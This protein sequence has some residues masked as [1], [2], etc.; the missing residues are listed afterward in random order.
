VWPDLVTQPYETRNVEYK[1]SGPWTEYRHKLARAALGLANTRDGGFIVIGV[2]QR[3]GDALVSTGMTQEHVDTYSTDDVHA[4]L[5][6]YANPGLSLRA[7][8]MVHDGL[9]FYV[10]EVNQFARY[11]VFARRGSPDTELQGVRSGW[12]YARSASGKI[13]TRAA[14]QEDLTEIIEIAVEAGLRDFVER[15]A[16]AGIGL[17][18]PLSTTSQYAQERKDL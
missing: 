6:S 2:E 5:N 1:Q 3:D 12:L 18:P 15:A 8:R 10:I 7:E 13:E 9:Q 14:T 16:R 17:Q 11:P 4:F